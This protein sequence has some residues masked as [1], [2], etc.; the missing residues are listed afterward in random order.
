MFALKGRFYLLLT[1]RQFFYLALLILVILY[2]LTRCTQEIVEPFL[3]KHSVTEQT[4]IYQQ[5]QESR[6]QHNL[7]SVLQKLLGKNA[8]YVSVTLLLE[9]EAISKESI[10]RDPKIV[11][12]TYKEESQTELKKLIK[13]SLERRPSVSTIRNVIAMQGGVLPGLPK[14]T[15]L[16]DDVQQLPGFPIVDDV[17]S[18]RSEAESNHL[19]WVDLSP[20]SRDDSQISKTISEDF[21]YYN[22]LVTKTVSPMNKV[23][24]LLVNVVIDTDY[25]TYTKITENELKNLLE[26]VVALNKLRGDQLNIRFLPFSHSPF[27][28]NRLYMKAGSL[29]SRLYT[30]IFSQKWWSLGILVVFLMGI[31]SRFIYLRFTLYKHRKADEENKQMKVEKE[32]EERARIQFEERKKSILNLAKERTNEFSHL[33]ENWLHSENDYI[34]K[35]TMEEDENNA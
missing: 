11:T 22:E 33:V 27:D 15:S 24:Q 3:D 2:S 7:E 35:E 9:D 4:L 6:I 30:V 21:T 25:L 14:V 17:G 13:E 19:N 31:I 20:E 5:S 23:R 32:N 29:F 18:N 1:L 8:F 10:T 12:T 28:F 26:G 16:P 34:S